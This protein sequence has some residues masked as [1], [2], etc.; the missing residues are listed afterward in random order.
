MKRI[1]H[2][3]VSL[4][5]LS[6]IIN[7]CV[8]PINIETTTFDNAIVIEALITNELKQ[9]EINLTRTYRLEENGPTEESNADVKIID[10]A[11]NVYTFVESSPGKYVSTTAFA[12]TP[13]NTYQLFITT[14]SGDSYTSKPNSLTSETEIESLNA[15][16]ETNENGTLGVS[17]NVNSFDPSG[18]SRYYRYEYE[19]TYK[20][21]APRWSPLN[22]VV[23]NQDSVSTE[24]RAREE[25]TCYN[26][27]F[28]SDIIQTQTS[29]FSE[30]RV[31]QKQVRFLAVDDFII[32]HRYSILVKQYV[33]SLEAFSYFKILKELSGSES[34]LSQNQ[35]GFVNGNIVSV[36]N[37]NEKVIGFFDVSS[38]S[39]KRLFF[40]FRDIFPSNLTPS[41]P[42]FI[43]CK[44]FAPRLD[45]TS[46]ELINVIQSGSLKFYLLNSCCPEEPPIIPDGGP[47]VMVIPECGDCTTI[48]TNVVPDFW[49]E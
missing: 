11:Q 9:H 33:Q 25:K 20:I 26:T 27:L 32:S 35:P 16:A 3:I 23:I 28:S 8:E 12:A 17:V 48:G 10:D 19:E 7:S 38:V 1:K 49:T 18:N 5:F 36:N 43:D 31:T 14:S 39:S 44:L 6:L 37:P 22:S 34:L 13:N 15:V 24:E 47:H 46:N 21:I 40:N 4:I 41:P 45:D 42:Y 29:G 2:H 30:D